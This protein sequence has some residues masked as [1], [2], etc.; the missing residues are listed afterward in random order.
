MLYFVLLGK[1]EF[2]E[3]DEFVYMEVRIKA[4]KVRQ[5]K[6]RVMNHFLRMK[7]PCRSARFEICKII[8]RAMWL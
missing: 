8:L 1:M 2:E 5:S 3:T 6:T 4:I 7:H